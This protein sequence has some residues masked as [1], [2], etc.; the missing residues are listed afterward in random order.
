MEKIKV[1]LDNCIISA[2]SRIEQISDEDAE[3][4]AQIS[5]L[6]FVD[7]ITSDK[8]LEELLKT[9]NEKR[10]NLFKVLYSFLKKLPKTILVAEHGGTYGEFMYGYTLYGG[11]GEE[12]DIYHFVTE[13][14][15]IFDKDDAMHI[16]YAIFHHCDYFLTIDEKTILNRVKINKQKL[17]RILDILSSKTKFVNPADLYEKLKINLN[18]KR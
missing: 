17:N 6:H 14:K 5:D 4:L 1:Y 8:S 3:A 16:S 11:W 7:F 18:H 15:K 9:P 2:I 13:I 12:E 10:R